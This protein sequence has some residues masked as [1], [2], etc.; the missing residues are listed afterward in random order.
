MHNQVIT[1]AREFGSGGRLI[2]KR[3]S[4]LL[5]IPFYDREVIEMCIRDRPPPKHPQS[6]R[7]QGGWHRGRLSALRRS[8]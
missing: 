2:G 3:L 5:Q 4:E 8:L 7:L 6:A 1:L